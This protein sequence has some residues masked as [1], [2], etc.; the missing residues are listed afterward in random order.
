MLLQLLKMC[1]NIHSHIH[2]HREKERE[3]EMQTYTHT[4]IQIKIQADRQKETHTY[5]LEFLNDIFTISAL[6]QNHVKPLPPLSPFIPSS[7]LLL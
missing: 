6:K 7:L 4:K 3:R 5:K 1:I 2:T